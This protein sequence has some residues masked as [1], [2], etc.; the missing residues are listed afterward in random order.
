M[1]RPSWHFHPSEITPT[2][3]YAMSDATGLSCNDVLL[4]CYGLR[5]DM[6]R[7]HEHARQELFYSDHVDHCR[8]GSG[9]SEFSDSFLYSTA[10]YGWLR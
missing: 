6:R 5:A 10:G 7:K 9:S 4:R 8:S 2:A 1:V 3:T